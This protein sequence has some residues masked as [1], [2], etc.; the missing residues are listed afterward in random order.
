M[1]FFAP[2]PLYFLHSPH[3]STIICFQVPTPTISSI[4]PLHHLLLFT[5]ITLGHMDDPLDLEDPISLKP[6]DHPDPHLLLLAKIQSDKVLNPRTVKATLLASWNSSH[7]LDIRLLEPNT[8]ACTFQS[9]SD[10]YT[11]L[12]SSPWSVKGAHVL[13]RRWPPHI[14]F[15]ELHFDSSDFW[16]QVHHLPLDRLTEDNLHVISKLIGTPTNLPHSATLKHKHFK[17]IRLR[18]SINPTKPLKTGFFLTRGTL[19]TVWIQFKYERLSDFCYQCRALGRTVG[20]CPKPIPN[21]DGALDPRIAF[22]SWLWAT[23]YGMPILPKSKAASPYPPGPLV[24]LL[25]AVSSP[26]DPP[27]GAVP[28]A[29]NVPNM[30]PVSISLPLAII[31]TPTLSPPTPITPLPLFTKSTHSLGPLLDP[32]PPPPTFSLI[33]MSSPNVP[34]VLPLALIPPL[35]RPLLP[36]P[37]PPKRM[38]LPNSQYTPYPLT[39]SPDDDP[40]ITDISNSFP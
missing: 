25:P 6:E 34:L 26:L 23:P 38:C 16:V 5:F 19:P 8:Y 29:G 35:K 1:L 14:T 40:L 32:N 30:A 11:V 3:P 37:V 4:F 7:I 31:S 10:V 9:V 28:D 33:P 20:T 18:V 24:V 12:R 15:V 17:F 39:V 27:V 13:L 22:G 2:F 21:S 36:P